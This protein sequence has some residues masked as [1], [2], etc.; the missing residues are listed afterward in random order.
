MAKRRKAKK[1]KSLRA[2][3][4]FRRQHGLNIMEFDPSIS[5]EG[6]LFRFF[7]ARNM[8][9]RWL[10]DE[11]LTGKESHRI[12]YIQQATDML[13][14]ARIIEVEHGFIEVCIQRIRT[15]LLNILKQVNPPDAPDP[16]VL[17][18]VRQQ[19]PDF[20]VR[21][22]FPTTY[23]A[24]EGMIKVV[25]SS[26]GKELEEANLREAVMSGFV[27]SA[28][29]CFSFLYGP[30]KGINYTS[31]IP[32]LEYDDTRWKDE[33]GQLRKDYWYHPTAWLPIL[34]PRLVD[35]VFDHKTVLDTPY[36]PQTTA[37]KVMQDLQMHRQVPPPYYVVY[38]DDKVHID[39]WWHK[40]ERQRAGKIR[41]SPGHRYD[42]R[43]HDRVKVLRGP[44]PLGEKLRKKLEKPRKVSGRGYRVFTETQPDADLAAI[45]F[46]R[47]VRR[48]RPDEWMA[49]LVIPID[50]RVQGPLDKPYVPSVR[51]SHKHKKDTDQEEL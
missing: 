5:H 10:D 20:P 6:A 15:E 27:I 33:R 23:F 44:L 50:H 36:N 4:L 37:P 41:Q 13:E 43:A 28:N 31:M 2:R 7:H 16:V 1:G 3:K 32:V 49:V 11:K 29:R 9:R 22:P 18:Y 51:K 17:R 30:L 25:P 24:F 47:G 35:W 26:Y 8:F 46:K 48:K 38:M 12:P 45:L 40:K 14:D 39:Q 19:L 34:A 21:L 42:V